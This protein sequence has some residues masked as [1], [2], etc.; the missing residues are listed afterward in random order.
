MFVQTVH[1][2]IT[3]T[4]DFWTIGLSLLL[5][6]YLVDMGD[7]KGV[8]AICAKVYLCIAVLFL[9]TGVVLFSSEWPSLALVG[10]VALC[11]SVVAFFRSRVFSK[12]SVEDFS[13]SCS[14]AFGLHAVLWFSLWLLWLFGLDHEVRFSLKAGVTSL[15]ELNAF[16]LWCSP[17]ML[18][19]VF[20]LMA[21]ALLVRADLYRH[22]EGESVAAEEL[23]HIRGELKMTL[24]GIMIGVAGVWVAAAIA[25]Q[26]I[27]LQ[28]TILRVAL[29]FS[30]GL[31]VYVFSSIGY[32][33]ML[34]AAMESK[35]LQETMEIL[36]S[37]WIKALCLVFFWPLVPVYLLIEMLHQAS[38]HCVA[39]V[40]LVPTPESGL[41]THEARLHVEHAL[42]CN[43]TSVLTKS[44]IAG[45][46]YFLMQAMVSVGITVF[47]AWLV[48]LIM[49]W[50]PVATIAT[51]FLVGI[52]L[53]LLPPVPGMPVYL[54]SAVLLVAQGQ[55]ISLDRFYKDMWVAVAVSFGIKLVAVAMQQKLIGTP[56]SRSIGIKSAIGVHTPVMKAVK[57]VLKRPGLDFDK[58]CVLCAGPDWPTSVFTGVLDL[59]LLQM[60]VGTL[61]VF[62]LI[63]PVVVSGAFMARTGTSAEQNEL[64]AS[65]A[66]IFA[67]CA[68]VVQTGSG[69][70]FCVRVHSL[71]EEF[72]A[73]IAS[74]EWEKDPDEDAV[75]ASI[76]AAEEAAVKYEA[77]VQW[78]R[79]PVWV[80]GV[81][82]FGSISMA[83]MMHL[84]LL[85]VF[86]PFAKFSVVDHISDLPGGTVLGAIKRD[87]WIAIG[88]MTVGLLALSGFK[89]WAACSPDDE[90]VPLC[91]KTPEKVV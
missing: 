23:K 5:V 85:P 48:D 11:V 91:P 63:L 21:V 72:K 81:L 12:Y 4:G 24:L 51:L 3:Y 6:A 14:A 38:R 56:F 30:A 44:I 75:L 18:S 61:P 80:Q 84:L 13:M 32:K 31:L 9:G 53:F 73:E 47:L 62:F 69:V 28:H 39:M 15:P 60:L 36:R 22:G 43:K 49:T 59:P 76:K 88:C 65:L 82:I 45:V 35:V 79:V 77:K 50:G 54:A 52:V 16:F 25:A 20:F 34:D 40:G 90:A 57:H 68:V 10:G 83:L 8:A 33:R 89:G 71:T 2:R 7:W 29:F 67:M 41:L 55:R 17:L 70:M 42:E 26:D 27:G 19:I 86:D 74:G 78:E 1:N 58:V 64:Y 87:G 46:I 66:S 37:D